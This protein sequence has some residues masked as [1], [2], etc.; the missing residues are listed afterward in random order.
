[1]TYLRARLD[2][3]VAWTADVVA[4][5][6]GFVGDE[7]ETR[8]NE[9]LRSGLRW[10][11]EAGKNAARA[12]RALD[13]GDTET[14]EM[15]RR[16]AES[17]AAASIE[18][19]RDILDVARRERTAKEA[20]GRRG[21]NR[22]RAV[23]AAERLALVRRHSAGGASVE[24]IRQRLAADHCYVTRRTIQRDMEKLRGG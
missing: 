9:D 8:A 2:E 16:F 7:S 6:G 21:A 20:V 3:I 17:N 19:E 14:A 5:T 23:E 24:D 11:A 1:M 22:E 12:L 4:T 10:R 18:R 15:Y 13:A